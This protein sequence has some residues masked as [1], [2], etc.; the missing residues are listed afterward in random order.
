MNIQNQTY[1]GKK[2]E[3][4]SFPHRSMKKPIPTIAKKIIPLHKLE[5]RRG[6]S[7]EI[8]NKSE[9]DQWAFVSLKEP[10]RAKR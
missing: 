8:N 7:C 1:F 2:I 4:S 3:L 5:I 6:Y 10:K 9:L